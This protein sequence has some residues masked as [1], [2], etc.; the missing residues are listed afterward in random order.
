MSI[1]STIGHAALQY[2]PYVAAPFTGGASL[3]LAPYANAANAVW[4]G[5]QGSTTKGKFQ[6]I[7]PSP[8]TTIGGG[9]G[10]SGNIFGGGNPSSGGAQN[11]NVPGQGV[12]KEMN[13]Y[14]PSGMTAVGKTLDPNTV[15]FYGNPSFNDSQSQQSGQQGGLGPSS[16]LFNSRLGMMPEDS[17]NPNLSFALNQGKMTALRNQPW[18]RD[19]GIYPYIPNRSR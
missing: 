8:G 15:S 7:G 17:S 14:G 2:G 1:W 12:L 10:N 4:S 9:V 16:N 19:A 11:Q 13:T 5:A 18:R 3:A 6:P